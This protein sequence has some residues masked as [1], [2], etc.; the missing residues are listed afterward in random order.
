M[1]YHG[2]IFMVSA[3]HFCFVR[4]NY[5]RSQVALE[6]KNPPANAGD[7]AV[8]PRPGRRPGAGNG[9]HSSVLARRIPWTGEPGGL[10]ARGSQRVTQHSKRSTQHTTLATVG[11]EYSAELNS[12]PVLTIF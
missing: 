3:I 11:T 2:V 4:S 12:D 9:T 6:V 5:Q 1:V 7:P 10:Q 8:I